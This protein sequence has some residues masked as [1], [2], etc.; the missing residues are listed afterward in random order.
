MIKG[1]QKHSKNHQN[2]SNS[3]IKKLK[4][5]IDSITREHLYKKYNKEKAAQYYCLLQLQKQM[6]GAK[7]SKKDFIK[8]INKRKR[9]LVTS[10]MALTLKE[11]KKKERQYFKQEI[12]YLDK[13][14]EQ[15]EEDMNVI[16]DVLNNKNTFCYIKDDLIEDRNL[17]YELSSHRQRLSL[18]IKKYNNKIA[19]KKQ[20]LQ[21]KI[22]NFN[23]EA[24]AE[25]INYGFQ[26][27]NHLIPNATVQPGDDNEM[28][29]SKRQRFV[30]AMN[31]NWLFQNDIG[32]QQINMHINDRRQNLIN[33]NDNELNQ[34]INTDKELSEIRK[35]ME[36]EQSSVNQLLEKRKK[37]LHDSEGLVSKLDAIKTNITKIDNNNKKDD[38]QEIVKSD[39]PNNIPRRSDN[40][41]ASLIQ[42]AD[43]QD[44]IDEEEK[45]QRD[46]KKLLEEHCKNNP[47]AVSQWQQGIKQIDKEK[48]QGIKHIDEEK[49]PCSNYTNSYVD[50]LGYIYNYKVEKKPIG[51]KG[52]ITSFE[53]RLYRDI[54]K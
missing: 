48:K 35:T 34:Y 12:D 7:I 26:N 44:E 31:W 9:E 41:E 38:S 17:D 33:N 52:K 23:N 14:L 10:K 36:D 53:Y 5:Q 6:L 32:Y 42:E 22:N 49:K 20:V 25:C 47:E 3:D 19:E 24:R 46:M 27:Y 11:E 1:T 45:K 40:T 4:Q 30:Q 39:I 13:L 50:H 51:N 21:D 43:S 2:K 37:L 8:I 16:L 28:V 29:E 18:Q 15:I 54:E